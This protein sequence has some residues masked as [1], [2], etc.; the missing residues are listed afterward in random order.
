[1]DHDSPSACE[2]E[3]RIGRAKKNQHQEE[4]LMRIERTDRPKR[5]PEKGDEVDEE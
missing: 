2:E 1:V 4:Y 5:H 3:M